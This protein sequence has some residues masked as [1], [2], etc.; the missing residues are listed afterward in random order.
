MG[1][2]FNKDFLDFLA[3]LNDCNVRYLLVGGYAVILHGYNRSTG[4]LDVWVQPTLENFFKLTNSFQKFGLPTEAISKDQFLDSN[5]Y[6]V[7]TFGISPVAIDI[8]THVKGLE[9]D[10]C[11]K[12]AVS[13]ETDSL[14]I[15]LIHYNQLIESKKNVGRL[16]DLSDIENLE[17]E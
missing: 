17:Q 3:S 11:Y 6:D 14:I 8:M 9:F 13:Y 7:F 5:G 2:I 4:D 1:S 10:F 16:K 15:P 12:N